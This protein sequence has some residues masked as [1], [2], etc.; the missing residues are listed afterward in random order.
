VKI[1]ERKNR[2]LHSKYAVIDEVWSTVGSSNLDWRSLLHNLELNAVVVG[3]EFGKRVEE[4]FA[5][6]L[7]NSEE[8]TLAKWQG[9]PLKD[10]AREAA[11]RLWESML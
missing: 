8:I 7:A 4:L 5:K 2:L 9:R 3:P 10:R 11:A 1:Y 6:D